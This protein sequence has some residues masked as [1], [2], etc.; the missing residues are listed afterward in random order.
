MSRLIDK[1][2]SPD[3]WVLLATLLAIAGQ[4][5]VVTGFLSGNHALMDVGMWLCAPLILGGVLLMV[6][7]I[8]L[9]IVDNWKLNRKHKQQ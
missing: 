9:L 6:V 8:P 7:V 1:L 5:C 3:C 2:L 4:V